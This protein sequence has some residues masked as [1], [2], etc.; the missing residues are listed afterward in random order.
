MKDFTKN[1]IS[2]FKLLIGTI[3]WLSVLVLFIY[4]LGFN[5]GFWGF[6]VISIFIWIFISQRAKMTGN[7]SFRAVV[8][9][10]KNSIVTSV[11]QLLIELKQLVTGLFYLA[12]VFGLVVLI[13][14]GIV[15]VWGWMF[16]SNDDYSYSGYNSFYSS[17]EEKDCSYLEPENPYDY[18]SGHYAGYEWGENGNYCSGNSDSFIEGCEEYESQEEAYDS[19]LNN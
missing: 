15:S 12:I 19:C 8:V 6:S 18:G 4:L 1:T 17:G 10:T 2:F 3:I 14:W 11:K 7:R 9:Y 16:S 13:G 5:V